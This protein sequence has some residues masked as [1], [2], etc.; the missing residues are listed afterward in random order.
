M[1]EALN[2]IKF[3]RYRFCLELEKE[4]NLPQYHGSML[5]GAFGN[6]LKKTVC[7]K[8]H[9]NCDECILATKCAYK[10]IFETQ[11]P[12]KSEIMNKYNSVPHPFIIEP[13]GMDGK[14]LYFN[15]ILIGNAMDYFPYVVY[16]IIE[17]GKTIGL[18]KDRHKFFLN[19]IEFI[20]INGD[21]QNIYNK[22]ENRLIT[23]FEPLC[24]KDLME[25]S[26]SAY[27]PLL[28]E[29]RGRVRREDNIRLKIEFLTWARIKSNGRYIDDMDFTLFMKNILRRLSA[30]A[31]FHCNN[32]L[33]LD[34]KA[35]IEDIQ[36]IKTIEKKL[37]WEDWTRYSN[38]AKTKM[39]LGG[40]KGYI[41]FEGDLEKF[42]PFIK[43][44]E[45]L[46]IG[47]EATFGLGRYKIV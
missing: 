25:E 11:P 23:N 39:L 44:G 47:K 13:E 38:R 14:N 46:H 26:N 28:P 42:Y 32:E 21:T 17:M 6:S 27:S 18:G 33:N 43:L 36:N 7:I 40:I 24:L 12:E 31:Y 19:K 15:F 22:E 9:G 8:R 35:I 16:S 1:L 10:Y 20:D 41:V 34:F 37:Y 3:A 2:N 45:Y 4:V 30:L 5:R 29:E